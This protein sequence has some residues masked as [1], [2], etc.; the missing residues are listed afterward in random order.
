M[1]P[2]FRFAGTFACLILVVAQQ[3]AF[4]A[5]LTPESAA[6][7]QFPAGNET[8]SPAPAPSAASAIAPAASPNPQAVEPAPAVVQPAPAV[9]SPT[10]TSTAPAATPQ[11]ATPGNSGLLLQQC[12]YTLFKE[13]K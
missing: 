13:L 1:S 7:Q 8:P 9:V 5:V 2:G 6:A 10:P 12:Q 3:S 4:A 11:P